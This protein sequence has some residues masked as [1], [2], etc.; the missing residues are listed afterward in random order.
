VNWLAGADIAC[1]ALAGTP[2][3]MAFRRTSTN[4]QMGLGVA[5]KTADFSIA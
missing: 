4:R 5:T 2:P 3:I 1:T